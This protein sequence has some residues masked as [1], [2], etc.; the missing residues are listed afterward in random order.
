MLA[1]S[2]L[3]KLSAAALTSITTFVDQQ[4]LDSLLL[5]LARHSQDVDSLELRGRAR[6]QNQP[7][8]PLLYGLPPSLQLRRL[9]LENVQLQLLPGGGHTGVLPPGAPIKQL[10]LMYCSVCESAS[11]G[12]AALTQALAQLPRREHFKFSAP[13][14]PRHTLSGLQQLTSLD[15][16][17][18]LGDVAACLDLVPGLRA[19]TA[20]LYG[21]VSTSGKLSALQQL[22]S[23]HLVAHCS[24]PS[25]DPAGL[26]NK[27]HLRHLEVDRCPVAGG[28]QVCQRCCP[29]C[30]RCRSLLLCKF[31]D[32]GR[33][34]A[35]PY[36]GPPAAAYTAL[37]AS[38]TLQHLHVAGYRLPPGVWQHVLPAGRQLP[39]LRVLRAEECCTQ[40]PWTHADTTRLVS[41]CP[42]LQ[43]LSMRERRVP[44]AADALHPLSSLRQLTALEAGELDDAG[45]AAAAQLTQLR[46][47]RVWKA[48]R[49]TD[50]GLLHLT[51]LKQ[52]STLHVWQAVPSR[53]CERCQ[54]VFQVRWGMQAVACSCCSQGDG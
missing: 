30:S 12:G 51:Q 44:M 1:H 48:S 5:Y 10:E 19:L 15:L 16:P 54:G 26:A 38:S 6:V 25:V 35:V 40:F 22:T 53:S 41:C 24:G 49:A 2:T 8:L 39:Q 27:S 47:L 36:R 11:G 28:Q 43:D 14:L 13:S 7:S 32:L 33:A 20:H 29:A 4:Q 18:A 23:L 45:D 46:D 3:H 42:N 9:S 50:A 34:T 21:A 17:Y 52:L 31:W 37:T